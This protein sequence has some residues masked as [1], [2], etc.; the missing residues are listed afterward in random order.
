MALHDGNTSAVLMTNLQNDVLILVIL[1]CTH[2]HIAGWLFT[3]PMFLKTKTI[4][5]ALI[6]I[7]FSA[8][9]SC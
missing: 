5:F 8:A 2:Q 1:G 3:V 7:I 9:F 6:E 4:F